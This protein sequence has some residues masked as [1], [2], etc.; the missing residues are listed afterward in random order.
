MLLEVFCQG[1][2]GLIDEQ[3]G[4]MAE[5]A[6]QA[7][8]LVPDPLMV[9]LILGE[10]KT[11]GWVANLSQ[12]LY[13]SSAG[14]ATA[15]SDSGSGSDLEVDDFVAELPAPAVPAQAS[16][17]PSAS[18]I[19]DGFPRTVS[20]A[21]QLDEQIPMNLV[22]EIVT[23]TSIILERISSRLVHAPSGRVY[24]TT[25]NPPRVAGRDDV[26]G[27]PLTRRADDDLDTWRCRL[28]KFD[29]TSRPLLEHYRRKNLVLTVKG[30]SSDEITPALFREIERKFAS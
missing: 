28:K 21:M 13:L 9:R 11:R 4:M 24:N 23:P 3:P 6:V 10:L 12:P 22:L 20:Q 30:N 17:D 8:R 7:G 2:I 14:A 29:E 26:T 19:L 16:E 15:M 25:F 27:E 18:F 5:A 1:D